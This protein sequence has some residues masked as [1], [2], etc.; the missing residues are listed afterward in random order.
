[1]SNACRNIAQVLVCFA[2]GAARQTLIQHSVTDVTGA[3]IATVYIDQTGAPV[4]TAA[5]TVTLGACAITP[6]DV[7]F[8]EMCDLQADG[9]IIEFVRRTVTTFDAVGT[10]TTTSADFALDNVTPYV[11]AGTVVSCAD[12][13]KPE[14]PLG[15]L[16]SWAGL[17]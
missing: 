4:N 12:E 11:V 15:V 1:M 6:P 3:V 8:N 5:G 10:P 9:S 13:C 16:T 17:L 7:E 14:A 2:N